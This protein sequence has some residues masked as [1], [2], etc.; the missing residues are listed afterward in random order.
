MGGIVDMVTGKSARRQAQMARQ[1][2]ADQRALIEKQEAKI[3]AI[4]DGQRKIRAGGGRG[5]LAYIEDQ[6]GA[7][8]GGSV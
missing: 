8:L 3:K 5:L 6:L 4:E 7:K 2:Q 1:A